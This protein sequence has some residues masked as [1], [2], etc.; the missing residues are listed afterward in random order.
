M[1]AHFVGHIGVDFPFAD[2]SSEL[3]QEFHDA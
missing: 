2:K 1:V 3:G